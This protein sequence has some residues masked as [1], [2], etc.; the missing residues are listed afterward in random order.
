MPKEFTTVCIVGLGYIGLPTAAV[1]ASRG[2]TVIGVDIAPTVVESINSGRAHFFEPELDSLVTAAVTSGRLRATTRPEP[3]EAF[4]IAVP[5]PVAEGR[6]PDLSHVEAAARSI[7]PA[8]APGALVVLESTSPV[9]T[10]ERLS[11]LLAAERPDLSFPHDAGDRAAIRIAYCPE[12]ILPGRMITELV[13]NDRIVGGL[14][15]ACSEAG[16]AFYHRFARGALVPTTAR[17]AE[18][19]KLAENAFRDVNIAFANELANVCD[20]LGVD[21]WE[22]I[23]LA[24]HHPRVNI[25]KPGPGVGGHCIAVDPWFLIHAEPEVTPLMRAAREVNDGRPAYVAARILDR[26]AEGWTI[27]CFGLTY[28]PDTD[29][30]RESPAIDVVDRLAAAGAAELLVVDPNI[31]RLPAALEGR[32]VR[33]CGLDEALETAD[34]AA[35]LVD[36]AVFRDLDPARLEPLVLY[37]ARGVWP[38]GATAAARGPRLMAVTG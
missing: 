22:A 13:E 26:A 10:T 6:A 18:L 5:T 7:A 20:R 34:M 9:G 29:D 25:L 38:E 16:V 36:H 24:N 27:A 2:A 11:T 37:D 8:L 28:K 32:G 23:A 15:P 4:V 14:S 3:A 19:V 31:D 17:S 12:R 21:V 35:L 30:L 33:L 1:L